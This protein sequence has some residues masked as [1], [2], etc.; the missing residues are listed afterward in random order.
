MLRNPI[1]VRYSSLV[2]LGLLLAATILFKVVE[3]GMFTSTPGEEAGAGMAF[4]AIDLPAAA[5]ITVLALIL[6]YRGLKT[7]PVTATL[8]AFI[9]GVIVDFVWLLI[10]L[11][12]W[13]QGRLVSLLAR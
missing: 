1:P 11:P 4:M 7:S 9:I 12:S 2:P 13:L 8:L 10:V 6:W 5:L 3:A